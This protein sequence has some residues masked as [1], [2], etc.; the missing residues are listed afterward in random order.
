MPYSA[1]CRMAARRATSGRI[2][3]FEPR[4]ADAAGLCGSVAASMRATRNGTLRSRDLRA[5]RPVP[6]RRTPK[7]HSITQRLWF[8]WVKLGE[9]VMGNMANLFSVWDRLFGTYVNPDSAPLEYA[10]IGLSPQRWLP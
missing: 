4:L 1:H 2:R 3:A 8:P 10:I 6:L 5:S 9:R 7:T